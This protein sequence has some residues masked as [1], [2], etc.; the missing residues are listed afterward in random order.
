ME[1]A[2]QEISRMMGEDQQQLLVVGLYLMAGS[3]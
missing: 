2:V 3:V 1:S